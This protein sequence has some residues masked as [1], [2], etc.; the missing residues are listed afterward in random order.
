MYSEKI[1]S[2]IT[3]WLSMRTD[4]MKIVRE[5]LPSGPEWFHFYEGDK[6]IDWYEF[7]S[8]LGDK[9]PMGCKLETNLHKF[10]YDAMLLRWFYLPLEP[11]LEIQAQGQKIL[12]NLNAFTDLC[13]MT[14]DW[15]K[16]RKLKEAK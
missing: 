14:R 9:R 6:E 1:T 4:H 5:H 13:R 8:I 15:E 11:S 3:R 16:Y 12:E 2:E 10:T 7:W